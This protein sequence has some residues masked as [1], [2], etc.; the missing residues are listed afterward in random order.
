MY[1]IGFLLVLAPL[2]LGGCV[3]LSEPA[4]AKQ[5]TIIVPQPATTTVVCSN[6]GAPPCY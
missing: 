5:S 4:P 1:K 2:S 6:G 3:T